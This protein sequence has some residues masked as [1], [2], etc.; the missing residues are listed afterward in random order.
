MP[1]ST[2]HVSTSLGEYHD[3]RAD[4]HPPDI[5]PKPE[6]PRFEFLD[7][8]AFWNE[9]VRYKEATRNL[10]L[11]LYATTTTEDATP[12]CPVRNAARMLEQMKTENIAGTETCAVDRQELLELRRH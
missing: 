3:Q 4:I 7:G 1:T 2:H 9:L 12:T 5:D 10:A 8:P 11:Q 6:P